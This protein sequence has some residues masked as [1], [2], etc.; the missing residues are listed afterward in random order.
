MPNLHRGDTETRRLSS[1]SNSGLRGAVLESVAANRPACYGVE[2]VVARFLYEA[3]SSGSKTLETGAGISTLVFALRESQHLAITPNAGEVAAIREYAEANGI[4]LGRVEFVVE[5]S[6]FYLPRCE[7]EDLD[8][9]LIDGKHAFPWPIIDWFYTADRLKRGGIMVLDDLQMAP[10]SM[11]RDFILEDPGWELER[12]V[13][14]RAVAVRKVADSV[15]DVSWHMQPYVMR[16]YG[17]RAKLL[18]ALRAWV[19]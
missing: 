8:L 5:A 17:R 14:N 4:P 19:G 10:V 3:V 12:S 6:D 15:L 18:R 16:R 13:G 2:A 7:R 11:L 1:A 9:V